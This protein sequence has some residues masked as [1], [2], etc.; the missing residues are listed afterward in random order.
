MVV[1]NLQNHFIFK[2]L[3]FSFVFLEQFCYWKK[4]LLTMMIQWYLWWYLTCLPNNFSNIK[5]ETNISPFHQQVVH[6]INR[7]FRVSKIDILPFFDLSLRII[8]SCFVW[9]LGRP[10]ASTIVLCE[11]TK[12]KERYVNCELKVANHHHS[13]SYDLKENSW[14]NIS[15]ATKCL[16][17]YFSHRV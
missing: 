6:N 7:E 14:S 1:E 9:N 4:W 3:I 8:F 13:N 15:I 11:I 5:I 12:Y 10:F 16:S 2:F 17:R